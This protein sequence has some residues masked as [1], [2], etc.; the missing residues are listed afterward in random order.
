VRRFFDD[1]HPGCLGQIND[2]R[3]AAGLPVDRIALGEGDYGSAEWTRGD[4]SG[5]SRPTGPIWGRGRGCPRSA[6]EV[7]DKQV[8]LCDTTKESLK[9][10]PEFK[11]SD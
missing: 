9:S 1:P 3:G 11:Y 10:L 4:G 8:M 7:R 5:A 6:L 2:F